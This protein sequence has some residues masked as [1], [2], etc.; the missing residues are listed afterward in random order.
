MKVYVRNQLRSGS[1]LVLY[2][3]SFNIKIKIV[4]FSETSEILCG[5]SMLSGGK[6]LCAKFGLNAQHG[7]HT[8]KCSGTNLLLQNRWADFHETW[9]V[10]SGTPAHG[11]MFN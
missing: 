1:F 4:V 2:P 10:V 3:R 6:I 8:Q 11:K 5:A 7:R 9:N